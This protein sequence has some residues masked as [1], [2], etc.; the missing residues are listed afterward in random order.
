MALLNSRH[1]SMR[2]QVCQQTNNINSTNRLVLSRMVDENGKELLTWYLL[3]NVMDVTAAELSRWYC[4]RWNIE[5]WFKLLKSDGF[6]LEDWQQSS[7]KVL[8][9]RLLVSSMACTLTFRLYPAES[10][11]ATVPPTAFMKY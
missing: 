6:C 1:L 8:F 10:T 5:S 2:F 4:L 7:G 11:T 9:R 3:S